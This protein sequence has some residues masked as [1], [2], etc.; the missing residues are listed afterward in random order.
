M[1]KRKTLNLRERSVNIKRNKK[2]ITLDKRQ[3]SNIFNIYPNIPL[4]T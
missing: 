2:W 1:S 3:W 4:P